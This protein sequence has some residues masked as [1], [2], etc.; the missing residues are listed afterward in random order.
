MHPVRRR[1]LAEALFS[2]QAPPGATGISRLSTQRQLDP[3]DVSR[4]PPP[5]VAARMISE[6]TSNNLGGHG[7]QGGGNADLEN[8]VNWRFLQRR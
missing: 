4:G 3:W 7:L 5:A 6:G 2:R 8:L 1:Q